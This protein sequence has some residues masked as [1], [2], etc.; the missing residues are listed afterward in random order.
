MAGLLRKTLK[1]TGAGL[2]LAVGGAAAFFY[3]VN[4]SVA[5]PSDIKVDMSPARIA[6]GKYIFALAD[7]DGCHSLRDFTRF[8]GPV[9]EHGRG[10]G[11]IFPPEPRFP[12]VI[13][14][15]NITPDKETGIGNWTDGEKIRAI[16]EGIGRGGRVLFPMMG[17][18]RFRNMSDEDVQSLVAYL[19]T[20][21]PVRNVVPRTSVNFPLNVLVRTVPKPAGHVPQPDRSNPLKYGEYLAGISGCADCHTGEG[22]EPFA[23]GQEFKF[24]GLQVVSANITPDPDTGIGAWTEETFVSR[25][26][27]KRAYLE[28]GSPK[29]DP[30]QFTVMP[31]LS[32]AELEP[33][34]LKA[35]Y[36]YLRTRAAVYNKIDKHPPTLRA[37]R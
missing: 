10:Q 21:E 1:F 18:P 23:G 11:F 32:L 6:R 22:G 37:S 28:H 12:G 16:R 33:G 13:A 34:D 24:P 3:L 19:N 17:Y 20:L 36:A 35:I 7:C 8:A 27:T 5:R 4:P 29:A 31:W 9:V 30:S 2:G 25:F 26:V 15:A 14:A